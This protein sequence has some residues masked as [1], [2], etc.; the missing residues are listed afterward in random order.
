MFVSVR[1]ASRYSK[2]DATAC[3][4]MSGTP[5]STITDED[6]TASDR[7]TFKSWKDMLRSFA[8]AEAE[9]AAAR[10]GKQEKQDEML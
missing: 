4:S 8:K 7:E 2:S 5:A 10:M 1:A 3:E 6:S 9:G